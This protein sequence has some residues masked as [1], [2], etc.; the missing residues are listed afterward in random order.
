MP[1]EPPGALDPDPRE[2]MGEWS[3]HFRH[4]HGRTFV[5]VS[6]DSGEALSIDDQAAVFSEG[7]VLEAGQS[8]KVRRKRAMAFAAL[9]GLSAR[10]SRRLAAG[11]A[12]RHV[13]AN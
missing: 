9:H 2:E 1:D 5:F 8:E 10:R 6:H 4:Q 12:G 13:R 11:R 3:T 7:W